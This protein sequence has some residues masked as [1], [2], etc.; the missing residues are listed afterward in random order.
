MNIPT[1]GLGSFA[2]GASSDFKYAIAFG[3]SSTKTQSSI[4]RSRDTNA[5]KHTK[6]RKPPGPTPEVLKIEGNWKAA[7]RKLISKRRPVDG[8]PNLE[9]TK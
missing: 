3:A 9:K 4:R 8:L 2:C 1:K 7:M 6:P 5:E